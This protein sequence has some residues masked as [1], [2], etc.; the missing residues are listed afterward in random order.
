MSI[1]LA[2][3]LSFVAGGVLMPFIVLAIFMW[4]E[5]RNDPPK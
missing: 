4:L 3:A 5:S 2:L 1:Y